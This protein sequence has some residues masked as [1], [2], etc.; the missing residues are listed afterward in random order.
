MPSKPEKKKRSWVPERKQHQRL[1]DNSWFYN[2]WRWRK[3]TKGFKERNPL[4][5]ECSK[6]GVVGA[7]KVCDHKERYSP[8]AKGWDLNNIKDEYF[9]PM[10]DKHHN[11]KSGK[12][13]HGYKGVG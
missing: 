1:I 4:C 7:T 8:T 5:I 9:N 2:D 10:C 6:E 12:E 13:A 11:S 3:F